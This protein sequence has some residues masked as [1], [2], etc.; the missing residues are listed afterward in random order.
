[1]VN[2]ETIVSNELGYIKIYKN[3]RGFNWEIKIHEGKDVAEFDKLITKL[4]ALNNTMLT[5]FGDTL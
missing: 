2:K 1:M 4:E 3:S 5:K